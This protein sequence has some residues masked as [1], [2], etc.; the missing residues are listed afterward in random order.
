MTNPGWYPDPS[1]VTG[2]FR[3]WDGTQWTAGI[4]EG[5]PGSGSPMPGGPPALAAG[6]YPAV[7]Y[8]PPQPQ[9]GPGPGGQGWGGPG[10]PAGPAWGTLPGVRPLGY[11]MQVAPKS[12]AVALLISF[13]IPGVGSM[14][15]GEVGVGVAIL[16]AYLFSLILIVVFIG[17][18]LAPVVWVLG[19]VHAYT[20]ARRWNTAHGIIS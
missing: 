6:P 19:M 13:F 17:I 8:R 3:F 20:G 12:P 11:P 10:G 7:A 5:V 18:L 2:Q 16:A 15:N 9:I 1:G 14:V 4:S